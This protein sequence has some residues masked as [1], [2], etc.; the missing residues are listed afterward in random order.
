MAILI[1]RKRQSK[2]AIPP[3]DVLRG[4]LWLA[5]RAGQIPVFV[6][7]HYFARP[8]RQWRFDFCWPQEKVA[9]EVEGGSWMP[10]GG[11][12]NRGQGF[13]NDCEKYVEATLRGWRVLRVTTRQVH[14]G[15]ALNWILRALKGGIG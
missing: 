6:E 4:Q 14:T 8:Q 1:I 7:E 12:H 10:G 9:V 2:K 5:H 15:L 11:R 3:A 13:E